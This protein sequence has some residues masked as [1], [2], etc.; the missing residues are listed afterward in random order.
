VTDASDDKPIVASAR[1]G[2]K[3][4][5][6]NNMKT[7]ARIRAQFLD[8]VIDGMPVGKAAVAVGRSN[9]W[10]E[11]TRGMHPEW[12]KAVTAARLAHKDAT[13]P[14]A[15]FIAFRR[16]HFGNDTAP[17][18]YRI[19]EAFETAKPGT[20]TVV[21]GWPGLGKSTTLIDKY[22]HE[23][24]RDP[25][26]RICVISEGQALSRNII[27]QVA[28]RMSD[29]SRF[30]TYHLR[31]GPFRAR[32]WEDSDREERDP[33]KR[34][35]T[36]DYFTILGADADQ[37][38]PSLASF[39]GTS[40]IY[41]AR[42]DWM[43]FDDIQSNETM[44]KT[45]KYLQAM[46]TSWMSRIDLGAG[47]RGRMLMVGSRVGPDDIYERLDTHEMIDNLV[48]IPALTQHIT[49]E[50]MFTRKG[51]QIVVNPDCPAKPTWDKLTLQQLAEVRAKVGEE[52]WARTYMQD[53]VLD[54]A[55]VFTEE[56]LEAAKDPTRVVGKAAV[57]TEVWDSIDP[58]LDSGICAY[59]MTAISPDKLYLLDTMGRTD[60]YRYED[61][62]DWMNTWSSRYRPAKWIIEQNNYQKG[63][64][65]TDDLRRLEQRWG[66]ETVAHQTGR[67]KNDPVMGVR[68]MASSFAN[69][70][71][72]IPWGDER[73]REVMQPLID[74]LRVWKPRTRGSRLKMDRVMT[75]WFTWMQWQVERETLNN[76]IPMLWR[77]S[78]SA[79]RRKFA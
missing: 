62:F 59:L 75:L 11:K 74:E 60:T 21:L 12:A 7:A 19:V 35:W 76:V 38:D 66:F 8:L 41:G 73:S 26:Q 6:K 34:A 72:S 64:L 23:L 58:A 30:A 27:G 67:N 48:T 37:K 54:G 42:Y 44:D 49:A 63:L 31:Y 71:I 43:V 65:Q 32:A 9:Q 51:K 61:T 68:M 3:Y 22:C 16:A 53:V 24:A 18:H 56:M 28:D 33:R 52:V 2:R 69:G 70:E 77:P 46:R 20:L 10:Y 45:D 17:H 78:W 1:T 79:G 40:R 15:D 55:S 47:K 5:P 36:A 50:E 4:R 13:L 14:G 39:G 29:E 25:N 57:G